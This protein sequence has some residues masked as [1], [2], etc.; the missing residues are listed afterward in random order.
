MKNKKLTEISNE[1]LIKTEKKI[2]ALTAVFAGVLIVLFAT[3][4]FLIIK[5][6]TVAIIATPVALLLLFIVSLSNWKEL[7]KEIKAR[8]L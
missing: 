5:K 1:E 2:K 6:G 8:N 3:A 4:L 7:K